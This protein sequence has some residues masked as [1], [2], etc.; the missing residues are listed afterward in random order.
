MTHK[1][2]LGLLG[3]PSTTKGI[4]NSWNGEWVYRSAPNNTLFLVFTFRKGKVVYYKHFEDL[5]KMYCSR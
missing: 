3:E 5:D 2:L 4:E 1:Q